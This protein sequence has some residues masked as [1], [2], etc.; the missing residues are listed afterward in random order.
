MY[1]K[2]LALSAVFALLLIAG[3]YLLAAESGAGSWTGE[4]IDVT[5]HAAKGA[6]GTGH[7]E[8]GSKCVKEGLPVGLLVN[9]TTYLLVGS[10]HKPLNATLADHVSHT[11]TVTGEKFESPGANV[12]VVKD[13]KMAKM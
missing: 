8:C 12:I 13:W 5:C 3:S 1:K 11:V 4:V 2:I 9:G 7:A 10:D 6:M